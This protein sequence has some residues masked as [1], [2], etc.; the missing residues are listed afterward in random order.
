[1]KKRFAILQEEMIMSCMS[2]ETRKNAGLGDPPLPFFNNI[3]ESANA[4]IKRAVNFNE[5]KMSMFCNDM[6]TLILSQKEDIDSAVIN[7]GPYRLASKF[8]SFEVQQNAWFKMNADQR[9][10]HLRKFHEAKCRKYI[11]IYLFG[12]LAVL[13]RVSRYKAIV[14]QLTDLVKLLSIY[15]LIS[16]IVFHVYTW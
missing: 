16:G 13:L 10:K 15:S 14:R 6:S 11:Y 8:Q 2:R 9:D 1:M 5:S 4:M 12:R 3:P 7:K